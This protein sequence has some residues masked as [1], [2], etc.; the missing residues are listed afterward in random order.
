MSDDVE[1]PLPEEHHHHVGATAAALTALERR[2][3]AQAKGVYQ[4]EQDLLPAWLRPTDG[5]HRW[6][7]AV[8]A[9]TAIALQ[10]SLPAS[11]S[12]RPHYLLPV[13]ETILLIGLIVFSP[14]ESFATPRL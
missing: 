3:L 14:A 11:L 4:V 8:A 7:M 1:A 12:L 13:L 2:L 5:E 10:S 6:Q 9:G